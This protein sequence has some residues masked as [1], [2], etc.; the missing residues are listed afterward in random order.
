MCSFVPGNVSLFPV[1][2][3]GEWTQVALNCVDNGL[4]MYARP[5]KK[6]V[7]SSGGSNSTSMHSVSADGRIGAAAF[8]GSATVNTPT[9]ALVC[10]ETNRARSQKVFIVSGKSSCFNT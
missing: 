3:K 4:H 10:C 8:T 6:S 7:S 9:T 5:Y 2:T 1:C